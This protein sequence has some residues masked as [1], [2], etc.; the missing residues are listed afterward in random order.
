METEFLLKL[1]MN[2]GV[3]AAICFYT[4]YGVNNTLKKQD[5]TFKEL[6]KVLDIFT[7]EIEK[8]DI[9]HVHKIEKL[10]DQ[11]RALSYKFEHLQ[12]KD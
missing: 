5:E 9:V 3:P 10:E 1:L 8:R 11:L 2:V 4:L 12:R 6:A 7:K